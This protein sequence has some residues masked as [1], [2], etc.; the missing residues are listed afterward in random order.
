MRLIRK[1]SHS[2]GFTVVELLIVIVVIAIL[3]AISIV[4]Y[5]GVQHRAHDARRVADMKAIVKALELYKLEHSTYP[6]VV[7]SGL[8]AQAG[9]EASARESPGQFLHQLASGSFGLAGGV[10]LDPINNG[11]QDSTYDVKAA[12]TYTYVYYRYG[13]GNSG[14][15]A[16][17]GAF[18]VL[19]MVRTATA[20]AARHPDSPGFACA[21]RDWGTDYP[22]V[23]GGF[24]N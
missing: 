8:G 3:A 22:W 24:V 9:W 18:Y 4:A 14:C 12:G 23:T 11:V 16:E 2:R 7:H 21:G 13:A 20:G 6:P 19:G 5:T 1:S 10:P 17:R 15:P